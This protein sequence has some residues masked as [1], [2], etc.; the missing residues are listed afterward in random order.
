MEQGGK[1]GKAKE[2]VDKEEAGVEEVGE[3]QSNKG[4]AS[5]EEA[6]KQKVEKVKRR[7]KQGGNG[8]GGEEKGG[9]DKR[10]EEKGGE[11]KG[12][13]EKGGEEK[14]GEGGRQGFKFPLGETVDITTMLD[15]VKEQVCF[16]LMNHVGHTKSQVEQGK[17][18]YP[19]GQKL[20]KYSGPPESSAAKRIEL[21]LYDDD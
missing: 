6:D 1:S 10:G 4:E 8:G 14:G 9:E 18:G 12:G 13:E 17:I 11:E 7:Q 19:A 15:G 3:E 5:E 16:F 2:E 20:G 21:C